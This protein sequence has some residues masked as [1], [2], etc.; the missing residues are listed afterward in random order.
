MLKIVSLYHRLVT[1]V[2]K[3]TFES[4]DTN[5]EVSHSTICNNL[6][7]LA[8]R[9]RRSRLSRKQKTCQNPFDFKLSTRMVNKQL[10][11]S[12]KIKGHVFF[13]NVENKASRSNLK[14]ANLVRNDN[15]NKEAEDIIDAALNMGLKVIGGRDE[16]IKV[17]SSKLVDGEI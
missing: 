9:D 14:L 4:K 17:L 2:D 15:S 8:M 11:A 6:K 1:M 12:H 7:C 16:G 10:N 3:V 5:I 13:K